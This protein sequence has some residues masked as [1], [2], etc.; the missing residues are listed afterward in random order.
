MNCSCQKVEAEEETFM[1]IFSTMNLTEIE[2]K[3]AYLEF[4]KCINSQEGYLDYFLF[5]NFLSKIVGE[6]NYKNAQTRYFENLRK[7]DNRKQNIKRIGTLIIL[8]SKGSKSQKI[9]TI[10]DHYSKYYNFFDEKTVKEFISDLIDLHTEN[11]L[12]SF[13]ENFEYDVIANM[14]EIY[15]KLRKRQLLNHIY[16]FYERVKIKNL[17]VSPKKNSEILNTSFDIENILEANLTPI[18]KP[19]EDLTDIFE[20]YNKSQCDP[21][22]SNFTFENKK[23]DE[24][25]KNLKEFFELSYNYLNGEYMRNWLY[26]DYIKEKSNENV[27]I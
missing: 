14:N 25:E 21:L 2:T 13:R 27:C 3:S 22:R 1:R 24:G 5:K 6:N 18:K 17:Q 8:L 7:I 10:Y 23:I 11:C 19:K 20:R 16:S 4:T 9:E 26:E 15:K 12:Q